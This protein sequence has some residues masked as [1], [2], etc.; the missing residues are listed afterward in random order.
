[1]TGRYPPG[2][3]ARHNGILYVAERDGNQ[4]FA[5]EFRRD[6]QRL[7]ELDD[8]R[9]Y[10]PLRRW[11]GRALVG[12]GNAIVPIEPLRRDEREAVRAH[13]GKFLLK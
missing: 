1:M 3:G 10:L 12:V 2:H 4:V 6:G 8:T 5:F 11:G 13:A 9:A 7:I